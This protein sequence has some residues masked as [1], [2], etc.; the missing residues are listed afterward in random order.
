MATTKLT[1][2]QQVMKDVGVKTSDSVFQDLCSTWFDGRLEDILGGWP[3]PHWE[4]LKSVALS[5]DTLA[6]DPHILLD[7]DVAKIHS[8]R[9]SGQLD[10]LSETSIRELMQSGESLTST[11]GTPTHW[12]L[13]GWDSATA[14]QRIRL[15]P[16]P[17]ADL[18]LEMFVDLQAPLPLATSDYIPLPQNLIRALKYGT[19]ADAHGFK[20]DLNRQ[21]R[22]EAQY[23]QA[24]ADA[25]REQGSDTSRE[26]NGVIQTDGYLTRSN[27]G[28]RLWRHYTEIPPSA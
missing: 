8:L 11:A 12:M 2:L 16:L 14:K 13:A 10:D 21:T 3:W 17:S 19:R 26:S 5:A 22:D 20:N 18:T 1:V 28:R 7:E 9:V 24:V 25:K 4:S 6:A 27:M 15:W 23:R